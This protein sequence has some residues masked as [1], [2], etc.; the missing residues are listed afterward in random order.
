MGCRESLVGLPFLCVSGSEGE[1]HSL[2]GS[3]GDESGCLRRGGGDGLW[4]GGER[5]VENAFEPVPPSGT[6]SAFWRFHELVGGSLPGK[7]RGASNSAWPS[8]SSDQGSK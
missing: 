2:G 1:S 7:K 8:S 4:F 5:P 3:G 6:S